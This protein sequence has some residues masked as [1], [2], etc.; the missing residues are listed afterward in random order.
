MF[1]SRPS[2]LI[3]RALTVA[4]LAICGTG[5]CF[6]QNSDHGLSHP[7]AIWFSPLTWEISKVTGW[8][9]YS[10]H[11]FPELLHPDAPWHHAASH[12]EVVSLPHNVVWSYPDRSAV[13]RFY[14]DHRFKA[15]F[16]FGM[17]F[18]DGSCPKGIEG[19]SQDLD[20]N[21]ESVVVAKLWKEAGGKLDYVIMDAPLGYGHFL[22]PRCQ[23]PISEVARRVA[24]T[25]NGIRVYFPDV[26]VVDA[27]GPA[28]LSNPEWLAM[29][30]SWMGEFR[31][32]TGIPIDAVALDLHWRDM[33]EGNS[34]QATSRESS[35]FFHERGV[36]AGLFINDDHSGLEITDT[37]WMDAN[38]GHISAVAR[39]GGLGLDF[40]LINGWMGHPQ[41]NL[42]EDDPLAYTSLVDYSYREFHSQ[43]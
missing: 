28:R 24:A 16:L 2:K 36:R 17:L 6:G 26:R 9:D 30:A 37:A 42:P 29:M 19:M 3:H 43:E 25:L 11:D 4:W 1:Y 35:A 13:V 10:P 34:W 27:E 23:L 31:H 12:I 33:R 15:A 32:F 21:R 22:E 40:V 20:I 18:N 7:P 14:Q 39:G 41:N 5:N 8:I 38:R